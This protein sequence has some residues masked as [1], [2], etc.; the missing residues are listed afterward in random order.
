MIVQVIFQSLYHLRTYSLRAQVERHRRLE[1]NGPPRTIHGATDGLPLP[2]MV[3][4][5]IRLVME[6]GGGIFSDLHPLTCIMHAQRIND[7]VT[8][9]K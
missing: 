5:P 6:G 9:S 2:Q 7:D 8:V 1:V 4:P 3:R